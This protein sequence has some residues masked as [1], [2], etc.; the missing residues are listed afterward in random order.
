VIVLVSEKE[1]DFNSKKI[2]AKY[3]MIS[4][5]SLFL[6][7]FV[8]LY[9]VEIEVRTVKFQELKINE[10]RL[11]KLENDLLGEEFKMILADLHYLH[12]AFEEGLFESDNYE[13]IT[14]NWAEFSTQR[15]IYDQIRF[16][17][18]FGNEKIRINLVNGES[19][20]VPSSKLQNKKDRY[21]FYETVPLSEDSV[22]VSPLDL[23][24][25]QGEIEKPYKPMIRFSTPIYDDSGELKGIIILNYLAE[26]IIRNFKDLSE[27]SH[28]EVVLLNSESYWLSSNDSNLEW[29]F[30][31]EDSEDKKFKKIYP[32]EWELIFKDDGQVVTDKG[33]F[34]F[35]PVS[36]EQII[37]DSGKSLSSGKVVLGGGR[38]FI[39]STVLKDDTNGALFIDN[40]SNLMVDVLKKNA[41]Y[42]MLIIIISSVVAFFIYL[43]KKTYTKIKYFSEFDTL[44]KTYNRRA[45]ILKLNKLIPTDDR[46][47][48]GMSLCFIDINGLKEV[49]DTL[50]HKFGDEL[51]I[52]AVDVLKTTIREDDFVVRLGGDEFL[53][54]F[55]QLEIDE[56]EEVW[57]RVVEAYN[58]INETE[59]RAYTI[60]VS[61]G[62][63]SHNKFHKS[64]VDELIKLADEKMY[65]EK[66]VI[67][68]N[69]DVIRKSI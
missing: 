68:E 13:K 4:F 20:V 67:K 66:R 46:R 35:R 2:V 42:F 30:M 12:Y 10:K 14:E 22:Y 63:V 60:S 24:I 1:L 15:K 69:L 26:N 16:I 48:F 9:Y 57:N 37:Y 45:G 27:S 51:I 59:K 40:K 11:V 18:Y 65:Q 50:G 58:K 34:T 8:L 32:E 47:K 44:T 7:S 39:V 6:I 23:N 38:W 52:T 29:N 33:L 31:F 19:N 5:A 53:I 25:E 43:N 41:I 3:F 56:A 55:N 64:P 17:D 62:I 36:L 28:D 21:Y 49:N 54:V 61:H